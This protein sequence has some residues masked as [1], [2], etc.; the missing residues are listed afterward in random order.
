MF[1]IIHRAGWRR[2]V[3]NIVNLAGIER[4]ADILLE[5]RESRFMPQM[6]EILHPSSQQVVGADHGVALRQQG[7]A[8][9]RTQKTCTA[10][11]QD[12][13]KRQSSAWEK[14][15]ILSKMET[16]TS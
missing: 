15:R 4:L 5:K 9:I 16:A 1:E 6:R 12:V 8:Q 13:Y 10:G 14:R 3:E 7:I 2:E 11:H